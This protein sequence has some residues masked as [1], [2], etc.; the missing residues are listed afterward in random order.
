MHTEEVSK[1]I[2]KEE[3]GKFSKMDGCDSKMLYQMKTGSVALTSDDQECWRAARVYNCQG[4]EI[5][6]D[7]E[8]LPLDAVYLSPKDGCAS[9][10]FSLRASQLWNVGLDTACTQLLY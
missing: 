7:G 8:G 6:P 9:W 1:A 10:N 4:K 5:S 3:K 2:F